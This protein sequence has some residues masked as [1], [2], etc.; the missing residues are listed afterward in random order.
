MGRNCVKL[1]RRSLWVFH[2]NSGGCNGCDI[3]LLNVF[4]PYQDTE[5]FGVK[6]VGSPRHADAIALTGPITREALPRVVRA[7][8]AVPDPKVVIAI[9]SCAC[10]GGIWYDS[11]AVVGGV[12][13]FYELL[14]E[15]YGVEPPLTVYVPG[16]P[17]RP[18]AIIHGICVLRGVVKQKQVA[19][20]YT[21]EKAPEIPKEL[22]G[23][24]SFE[25]RRVRGV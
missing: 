15:R 4:A 23:V 7:F 1:F 25:V 19:S 3:E 20:Y 11:H 10:G 13:K 9:G 21:E 24:P 18:E 16:C 2:V 5:R 14:R 17:P 12:G 6:L 22:L 8:Q